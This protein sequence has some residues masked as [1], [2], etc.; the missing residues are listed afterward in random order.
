MPADSAA[1][2]K[3]AK[4]DRHA[5]FGDVA[6]ARYVLR[7]VFRIAEEQ[8]RARGIDPLAHQALI[9]IYGSAGS[10]LRVSQIAERLDIAPAFASSLVR[11]LVEDGLARRTRDEAD[12]RVTLVSVT[13]AAVALLDE[14]DRAVEFHVGYFA[15]QI[16]E[17]RRKRA[18]STLKFYV[19]LA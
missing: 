16:P 18:L 17:A 12:Q 4:K 14:I 13:D 6:E 9:Q 5:Y 10:V 7:R 2:Q 1:K 15:A 8:A 3:A 19:G 11:A